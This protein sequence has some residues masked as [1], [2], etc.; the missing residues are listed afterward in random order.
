MVEVCSLNFLHVLE[1]PRTKNSISIYL[2]IFL[3]LLCFLLMHLCKDLHTVHINISRYTGI[4]IFCISNNYMC[5]YINQFNV[6]L[7]IGLW[8]H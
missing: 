2:K 1:D 5:K 6:N 3:K 4:V 7:V 8:P